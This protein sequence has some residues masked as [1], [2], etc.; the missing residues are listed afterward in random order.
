MTGILNSTTREVCLDVNTIQDDTVEF[1]ET[2]FVVLQSADPVVVIGRNLSTGVIL[3]DDGMQL[4]KG[5][6]VP[7]SAKFGST[8]LQKF[9]LTTARIL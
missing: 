3:D 7:H 1:S 5:F 4:C 9:I 2:F 6:I 8:W